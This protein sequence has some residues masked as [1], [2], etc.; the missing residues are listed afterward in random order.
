MFGWFS[1]GQEAI[2]YTNTEDL[3]GCFQ[4]LILDDF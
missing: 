1:G 3:V 4:P 2:T